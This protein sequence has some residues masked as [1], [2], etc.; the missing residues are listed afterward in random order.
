[1]CNCNSSKSSKNNNRRRCSS[2]NNS[3]CGM[4]QQEEEMLQQQQI[5]PVLAT[6][7]IGLKSFLYLRKRVQYNIDRLLTHC[8]A[9][10]ATV[11]E[12]DEQWTWDEV[13][14]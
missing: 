4:Q 9:P 12:A 10:E 8:L 2:N 1:M 13:K 3:K 5:F 6:A 7:N 11:R 14:K